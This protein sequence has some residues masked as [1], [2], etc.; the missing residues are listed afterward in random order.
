MVIAEDQVL[1]QDMK[2]KIKINTVDLEVKKNIHH[3]IIISWK[4]RLIING[5]VISF[6]S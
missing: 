1:N 3:R 6:S 4:R 2:Q 5:K